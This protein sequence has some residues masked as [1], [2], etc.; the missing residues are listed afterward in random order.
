MG[1]AGVKSRRHLSTR[2]AALIMPVVLLVVAGTQRYRSATE[3]QSSWSGAG[4]GMF[5]TLNQERLG[6]FR[7]VATSPGG[8]T[9]VPVPLELAR[10]VVELKAD[11]V[12]SGLET[13]AR[14]WL[15][16][17]RQRDPSIS[18]L[19]VT[20]WHVRLDKDAPGLDAYPLH[21]VVVR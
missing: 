21:E 4:F 20:L 16:I 2:V 3:D 14:R 1:Q 12:R 10:H 15:A 18:E 13:L 17:E 19:R 6:F 9:S 8:A 5:A 7:A 11:P